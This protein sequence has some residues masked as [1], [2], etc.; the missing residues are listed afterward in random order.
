MLGGKGRSLIMMGVFLLTA[1]F[2]F[3]NFYLIIAALFII[4][5]SFTQSSAIVFLVNLFQIT[6]ILR[7]VELRKVGVAEN[8]DIVK[9]IVFA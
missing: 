9:S 6:E 8:L 7:A 5:E 4:S 2:S 1:G 3:T